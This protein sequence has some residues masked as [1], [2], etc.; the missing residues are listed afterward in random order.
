MSAS[1]CAPGG[2]ALTAADEAF[3]SYD[4]GKSAKWQAYLDSLYPTPPLSKML[5]WKKKFFKTHENPDFDPDSPALEAALDETSRSSASASRS[6]APASM[7]SSGSAPAGA[8]YAQYASGY[9][10]PARTSML[11][12][13]IL[14]PVCALSL[15]VGLLL[16]LLAVFATLRGSD[17]NSRPGLPGSLILATSFLLHLYIV[18]G[19]PPIR[20]SNFSESVSSSLPTYIQHAIHQDSVHALLYLIFTAA[21]P[22]SLPAFLSPAVSAVLIFSTLMSTGD[23]IPPFVRNNA[24]VRK[25]VGSVQ[26]NR[27]LLMQQ[28]ADVEVF[29]G[30][31]FIVARILTLNFSLANSILP[32]FLYFHLFRLRYSS[33]GFTHTTFRRIDAFISRLV[34]KPACPPFVGSFYRRIQGICKA[35]VEPQVPSAGSAAQQRCVIQ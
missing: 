33:C 3:L 18:M 30:V 16:S 12:S 5:K 8:S 29:F 35:L 6:Q 22:P 2:A 34:F 27:M 19:A 31:F 1:S 21:M 17:S 26:G 23:G 11:R 28:R 25:L 13:K 4:W 24:L 32:A 10:S 9:T 14:P 20:F 15:I 7:S